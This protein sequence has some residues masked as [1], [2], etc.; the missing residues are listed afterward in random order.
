MAGSYHTAVSREDGQLY[1]NGDFA[2]MVENTGDAYETAQEMYG[3]IWLLAH[4]LGVERQVPPHV[5][6]EM[7]RQ[8]Y[9]DGLAV[10]PGI[11]GRLPAE[12]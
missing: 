11:D 9:R 2:R 3:M 10:S 1:R 12:E 8:D 7:A 4:S 5:L 6:V